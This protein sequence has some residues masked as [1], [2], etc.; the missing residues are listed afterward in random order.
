M[1]LKRAIAALVAAMAMTGGV[2]A[3]STAAHAE[4]VC[5]PGYEYPWLCKDN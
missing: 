2:L 1:K 3:L 4:S 5:G